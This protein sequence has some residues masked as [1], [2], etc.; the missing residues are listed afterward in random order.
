MLAATYHAPLG[1][2]ELVAGERGLVGLWF[3]D[4]PPCD[5]DALLARAARI[6][7][8][9]AESGCA[10]CAPS[11]SAD[12][13]SAAVLRHAWGW[14][15][16]YFA[17]QR[18]RWVPPV[19]FESTELVHAVAAEVLSIE[20]AHAASVECLSEKLAVRAGAIGAYGCGRALSPRAVADAL[21][22]IPV[23]IVIPTHRVLTD[24]ESPR[25][26][27]LREFEMGMIKSVR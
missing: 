22:S 3:V 5:A 19:H 18:P 13:A 20:F 12:T 25:A 21:A 15:N 9:D 1:D 10:A 14:L 11:D 23:R 7:V 24:V 16:A 17:G 27:E 4:A 8:R 6:E 26:A 2:I